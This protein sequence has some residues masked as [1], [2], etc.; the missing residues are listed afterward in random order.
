MT[1]KTEPERRSTGELIRRYALLSVGL[2]V[3][4]C[5]VAVSIK[6][7]LGT[8]PI[9]SL[10][11]VISCVT[12][13]TVGTATIAMHV[14]LILLQIVLLR[15]QFQP[16]QLL[17]LPVALLFGVLCD[18]AVWLLRDAAAGSYAGQLVLCAAGILLVGIGVS[19]EVAADVVVLAG[20]GVVLAVCKVSR[21]RF[22]AAKVGFDVSLVLIASAL[23]L[24]TL[25]TLVGVR[26]GTAAAAVCVG[27][28]AKRAGR[29]LQ[30]PLD[31]L[32]H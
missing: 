6:A 15:R 20:E 32:L 14:A 10:P 30:K 13:L 31:R 23:S 16:V 3:M 22:P 8:S 1:E 7:G 25:G 5:G 2:A 12:P 29:L 9:S 24:L 4:A 18:G 17:Q 28:V 27:L 19:L 21:I 26:E 11:Y